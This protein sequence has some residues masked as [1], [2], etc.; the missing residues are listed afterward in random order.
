MS[1][2]FKAFDEGELFLQPEK[3]FML[4]YEDKEEALSVSYFEVEEELLDVV[5]EIVGYGCK[6]IDAIE[7]GSYRDVKVVG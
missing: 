1:E 4:I 5:K 2:E 7:I 6:V 3:P